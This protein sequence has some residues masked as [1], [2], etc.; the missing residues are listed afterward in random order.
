MGNDHPRESGESYHS[1]AGTLNEGEGRKEGWVKASEAVLQW[2][3]KSDM[4]VGESLG[5]SCK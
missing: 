5:Q 4:A 3:G 2:E 1:K